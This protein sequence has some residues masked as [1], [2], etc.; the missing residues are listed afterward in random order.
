MGLAIPRQQH[1]CLCFMC[2]QEPC[3]PCSNRSMGFSPQVRLEGVP[4]GQVIHTNKQFTSRLIGLSHTSMARVAQENARQ[5]PHTSRRLHKHSHRL[6]CCRCSIPP[7][8]FVSTADAT[9]RLWGAQ[10]GGLCKFALPDGSPA[11]DWLTAPVCPGLPTLM[12]AEQDMV[13]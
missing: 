9:G 10:D 7:N 1:G 2:L 4:S 12:T 8:V 3:H 11:F 5:P 6:R 13:R